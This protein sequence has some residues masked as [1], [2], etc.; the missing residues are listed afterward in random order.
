MS[1]PAIYVDEER[2]GTATKRQ[3]AFANRGQAVA[4][5]SPN[6]MVAS[7]SRHVTAAKKSTRRAPLAETTSHAP[8]KRMTGAFDPLN[9]TTGV[10]PR[11][12]R[13]IEKNV[14]SRHE[15]LRCLSFSSPVTPTVLSKAV[16]VFLLCVRESSDYRV[17][18]AG[19]ACLESL[20]RVQTARS[21]V[22]AHASFLPHLFPD[23]RCREIVSQLGHPRS[24]VRARALD[25]LLLFAALS[26]DFRVT[27]FAEHCNNKHWQIRL[28]MLQFL[29]E[30]IGRGLF[31]C[32]A[33]AV[34]M[35]T[36]ILAEIMSGDHKPEVRSAATDVLVVVNECDVDGALL[37]SLRSC[38][39]KRSYLQTLFD[40][41][42]EAASAGDENA[43]A[44]VS[45]QE[46]IEKSK[47]RNNVN[48]LK[49]DTSAA[50]EAG[51]AQA[52]TPMSSRPSSHRS[53]Q[54]STSP[55]SSPSFSLP[56]HCDPVL[57]RPCT[58]ESLEK[59]CDGDANVLSSLQNNWEDR[60]KAMK[61][62][63]GL[64]VGGAVRSFAGASS[65]F[66]RPRLKEALV[67]QLKDLRSQI[68]RQACATIAT[69]A[70]A[71]EHKFAT[72]VDN[73]MPQ[74]ITLTAKAKQVMS[75]SAD[76]C[77]RAIVAA[78]RHRGGYPRHLLPHLVSATGG[79]MSMGNN[80]SGSAP[81]TPR[82]RQSSRRRGQEYIAFA[83]RCWPKKSFCD[84]SDK[85]D[86]FG[87]Q[88]D[89][90]VLRACIL[91][92]LKDASVDVRN[93]A[94]LSYWAFERHFPDA[95]KLML[96][97]LTTSQ[98]NRLYESK[99]EVED[100]LKLQNDE[101]PCMPF[102]GEMRKKTDVPSPVS[103]KV[104]SRP[105]RESATAKETEHVNVPQ[106]AL[107]KNITQG[108]TLTIS[109]APIKTKQRRTTNRREQW[110]KSVSS[111]S[112]KGTAS[113][114]SSIRKPYQAAK[115]G[116]AQAHGNGGNTQPMAEL[117]DVSRQLTHT[118]DA[119]KRVVDSESGAS[120][121]EADG[122]R[123]N[124]AQCKP[125]VKCST[126]NVQGLPPGGTGAGVEAQNQKNE[127]TQ[128]YFKLYS[129]MTKNAGKAKKREEERR[130]VLDTMAAKKKGEKEQ[131][132]PELHQVATSSVSLNSMKPLATQSTAEQ[133]ALIA[134]TPS[135]PTPLH[136]SAIGSGTEGEDAG[137]FSTVVDLVGLLRHVNAADWKARLS[138]LQ[139][140]TQYLTQNVSPMLLAFI[141]AG[142]GTNK[143]SISSTKVAFGRFEKICRG[144]VSS[145]PDAHH[146]VT[147]QALTVL[148]LLV[149][150]TP[151]LYGNSSSLVSGVVSRAHQ[152]P[153]H[154]H[155]N[156]CLAMV[157]PCVF[158]SLV[159]SRNHIRTESNAILAGLR[160]RFSA[161]A[162]LLQC[163]AIADHPS[164][165]TRLGCQEFLL[166]LVPMSG[167]V[168]LS[169]NGS[170]GDSSAMRQAVHK[171]A[172]N[173][174]SN[175]ASLRRASEAVLLALH[176]LDSHGFL[177]QL[178]TLHASLRE[179][180]IHILQ[181]CIPR[182]RQS[183][184]AN[185]RV[186]VSHRPSSKKEAQTRS[187]NRRNQPVA[188]SENI[189]PPP[190]PGSPSDIVRSAKFNSKPNQ[191]RAA[192]SRKSQAQPSTPLGSAT[193]VQ[194]SESSPSLIFARHDIPAVLAT[195]AASTPATEKARGLVR[196]SQLA[197][198]LTDTNEWSIVFPQLAIAVVG[199]M[200]T[201]FSPSTRVHALMALRTMLDCHPK[202]FHALIDVVL[203]STLEACRDDV[204]D[205]LSSAGTTLGLMA[206]K[207]NATHC[208]KAVLP[209]ISIQSEV[210]ST[211]SDRDGPSEDGAVL[212]MGLRTLSLLVPRMSSA[213]VF[214]ALP[215]LMPPILNAINSA[216]SATRK[217]AVF[218]FVRIYNSVGDMHA[219]PYME[220]LT[221]AQ[222]KLV[223]IYVARSQA[224]RSGKS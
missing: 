62:L 73:F 29:A 189:P 172:E 21:S 79:D 67:L 133:K 150:S 164:Q 64:L 162:L 4:P 157:L 217:E 192:K 110:P 63:Q 7:A 135:A 70:F 194:S 114:H 65:C 126:S 219:R 35:C 23:H 106:Q 102:F 54:A 28:G 24:Q 212:R 81:P 144:I 71:L 128:S 156:A 89:N 209:I 33:P 136:T 206:K 142:T 140:V 45:Q 66:R 125:Q 175:N 109:P 76:Q 53:S 48:N 139:K 208:A 42:H 20:I 207:L 41:F 155:S 222:Q 108:V 95:A 153:F 101:I 167:D 210:A 165:K 159:D 58:E 181:G 50:P 151:L 131:G 9:N 191:R 68:V 38:Q 51:E 116:N 176:K 124:D 18:A 77:I 15:L 154:F 13:I 88:G 195:L 19:L 200:S 34:V 27:F 168:L 83:L 169:K 170:S 100:A 120:H 16:D 221:V 183:L 47:H 44:H 123:T 220:Q 166:H 111:K 117:G 94:R 39:L 118:F 98:A 163:I 60:M 96:R 8:E 2:V 12:L 201:N 160:L 87:R 56:M 178:Q 86:V 223:T 105:A 214:T 218:L 138:C 152:N 112:S 49:V 74:L 22:S 148:R 141:C 84:S 187:L 93:A 204:Q 188:P 32:D 3:H 130:H 186:G 147:A 146:K 149:D 69:L 104:S 161:P 122:V 25:C 14:S 75:C 72:F 127:Q 59:A 43:S 5:R 121:F 97:S 215:D 52:E 129:S 119:T 113:F 197:R 11:V 82:R 31:P 6:I 158:A 211:E 196:V 180:S 137:G 91:S 224:G 40:R 1:S 193:K 171:T 203:R 202:P 173:L 190:P 132:I 36:P 134:Q 99:S 213:T 179:K 177:S 145:I 92:S 216:A 10:T 80:S 107:K 46:T 185:A 115:R 199:T 90:S 143:S 184:H 85:E 17:I 37:Q 182:L 103:K 30:S 198:L 61:H 55:G 174:R 78:N 205:V 26:R 57:L